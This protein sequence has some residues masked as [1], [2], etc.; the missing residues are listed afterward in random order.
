MLTDPI[1]FQNFLTAMTELATAGP[2]QLNRQMIGAIAS[3]VQTIVDGIPLFHA[4]HGNLVS[5]GGAP[6]DTNLE[7]NRA[8]HAAQRAPGATESS[9][10]DPKIVL[11]PDALR[12]TAQRAFRTLLGQG[13]MVVANVE[14]AQQF[15]KDNVEVLSD[16]MLD[17]YS[18]SRWYSLV[19]PQNHGL[20]SFV[21]RY[22]RGYGPGRPMMQYHDHK[23]RGLCFAVDFVAGF[24]ITRHRGIV[25]N[26]A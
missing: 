4:D 3:N 5:P 21:Y 15:F 16:P 17:A 20:R 14:T 26:G 22:L 11:V 9:A 25:R 6:S 19:S 23:K 12:V 10:A 18:T 7:A 13:G 24:A 2:R 8:L 1:K